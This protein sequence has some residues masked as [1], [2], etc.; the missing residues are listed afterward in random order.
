MVVY[1]DNIKPYRGENNTRRE[2]IPNI[3][4]T[5]C[6][7]NELLEDTEEDAVDDQPPEVEDHLSSDSFTQDSEMD[8]SRDVL[9]T[10]SSVCFVINKV[11]TIYPDG[12]AETSRNSQIVHCKDVDPEDV[13]F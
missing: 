13:D 2:A 7:V 6:F 8:T 9:V 10:K 11:T 1:S 5:S 4:A 3:Q 12:C